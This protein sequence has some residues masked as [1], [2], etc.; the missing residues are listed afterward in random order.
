MHRH[1][2]AVALLLA[3]FWCLGQ[4][5]GRSQLIG[6]GVW[7]KA[8]VAASNN[9]ALDTGAVNS[10]GTSPCA[11]TA[12]TTT[13]AGLVVVFYEQNGNNI[14]I[15]VSGSTLGSFT[16]RGTTAGNGI[17]EWFHISSGALASETITLTAPNNPGG[18]CEGSAFNVKGVLTGTNNGYDVNGALPNQVASGNGSI[19]TSNA[20]DFLIAGFRGGSS[21]NVSGWNNI[22]TGSFLSAS[23]LKVT[24]IQSPLSVP[25]P[26]TNNGGI[27]DALVSN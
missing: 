22:V 23:W 24:T 21:A 7:K 11:L 26:N 25:D 4:Q 14:G 9:T 3:G 27:S 5:E 17:S 16:Q 12:M 18:F 13:A 6:E 1:V 8:G 2:L 10:M 20:N 19:T 15:T